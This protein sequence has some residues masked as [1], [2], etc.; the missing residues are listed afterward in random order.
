MRKDIKYEYIFLEN[1]KFIQTCC[2]IFLMWYIRFRGTSCV[3]VF[4]KFVIQGRHMRERPSTLTL[5]TNL[6]PSTRCGTCDRW[7]LTGARIVQKAAVCRNCWHCTSLIPATM[8]RPGQIM[9]LWP[10]LPEMRNLE[11]C[12][13]WYAAKR[14]SWS[15][16]L[17]QNF[18]LNHQSNLIYIYIWLVKIILRKKISFLKSYSQTHLAKRNEVLANY[19]V[20]LSLTYST[21]ICTVTDFVTNTC[22]YY[23]YIY[24]S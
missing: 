21:C 1:S 12:S 24:A 6:H 18:S 19:R 14:K 8:I 15:V 2:N 5:P 11:T 17:S 13:L 7:Y 10:S 20:Y 23:I 16:F 9:A 22:I 3:F 4:T